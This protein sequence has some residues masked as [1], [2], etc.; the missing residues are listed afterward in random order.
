MGVQLFD[1][2]RLRQAAR[3]RL[4]Q[5]R[6]L[7]GNCIQT[8]IDEAQSLTGSDPSLA[9]HYLEAA[10]SEARATADYP[11]VAKALGRLAWLAFL[12]RDLTG[13][14][15]QA[16]EAKLAAAHTRDW[17]L[18]ASAQ[19]V[20]A[21]IQAHI[22]NFDAAEAI[23]HELITIAQTHGDKAREADYYIELGLTRFLRG[24]LRTA[25]GAFEYACH[26]YVALKD[27]QLS[28]A[29]NNLAH[30][31]IELNN[32]QQA[33][34]LAERAHAAALPTMLHHR[35]YAMDTLMLARIKLG[36]LNGAR[37]ANQQL[38]RYLK[39]FEG[40]E[41]SR[42]WID[43]TRA[44]LALAEG[45][46]VQALRSMTALYASSSDASHKFNVKLLTSLKTTS[47]ATGDT[48]LAA[49]WAAE[50]LR[51]NQTAHAR[52]VSARD[53]LVRIEHRVN[54][55]AAQWAQV[56]MSRAVLIPL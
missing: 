33:A 17:T 36:D 43:L 25:I 12:R 9:R 38:E 8:M 32:F 53:A 21:S 13:A 28:S 20:L 51:Y 2:F 11:S 49:K 31:H 19:F 24:H 10:L 18:D 5:L 56:S 47:A 16:H 41:D 6:M 34:D 37:R 3:A 35:L 50:L 40:V 15:L 23:V 14:H 44:E 48:K 1:R 46:S 42:V 26:S 27:M 22:G 7:D 52:N 30:V 29:L 39:E 54:E 4:E 55:L 45:N